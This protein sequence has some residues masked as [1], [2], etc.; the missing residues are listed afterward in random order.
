MLLKKRKRE[1]PDINGSSMAD[2]AFLLLI[3]FLV[4][5]TINVD[6]GIGLVLPPPLEDDQEP[7]PIKERNLMNILVNAEG[8]ILMDDEPKQISDVKPS[9]IEF[10][11]NPTNDPELAETPDLAIVSIK[12]QRQTPYKIYVNML[13][14]VMGAYKDLRDEASRANYGV[15]YG[16]LQ[17]QSPQQEQV[18]DMYPKKISIA[19]GGD[20]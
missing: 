14:E 12:T 9:L 13:D 7:P 1:E 20:N 6:T 10:I 16:A 11:K 17:D 3:F 8:R 15:P 19:E 4:T 18:K 5:T 2:I